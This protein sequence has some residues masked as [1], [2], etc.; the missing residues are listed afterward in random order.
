M[1]INEKSIVYRLRDNKWKRY[2]EL[3]SQREVLAQIKRWQSEGVDI[4]NC[5][6]IL[7]VDGKCVI[8][9]KAGK[10]I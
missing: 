7:F 9:F 4:D 8:T 10:F 3:P 6:V 1:Q 2:I 5:S